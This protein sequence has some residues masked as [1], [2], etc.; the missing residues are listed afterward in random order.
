MTDQISEKLFSL[1]L[2]TNGFCLH[3][4]HKSIWIKR[5]YIKTLILL[6]YLSKYLT[7]FIYFLYNFR[8]CVHVLKACFLIPRSILL[9]KPLLL[10]S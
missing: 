5:K 6:K 1:L 3:I 4:S 9:G 2:H 7:F 10:E 8:F